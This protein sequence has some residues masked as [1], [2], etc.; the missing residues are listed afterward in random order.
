MQVCTYIMPTF[1]EDLERCLKGILFGF[2]IETMVA[3][4]HSYRLGDFP[5]RVC[6]NVPGSLVAWSYT[7]H[8]VFSEGWK[9][10]V[11]IKKR[12]RP[13]RDHS[14]LVHHI[15]SSLYELHSKAWDPTSS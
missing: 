3:E 7:S 15:H 2:V 12:R 6:I 4:L 8:P 10:V 14:A 13:K 5:L 1:I 11:K 9:P